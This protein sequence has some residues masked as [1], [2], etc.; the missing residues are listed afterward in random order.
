MRFLPSLLKLC[1]NRF[2]HIPRTRM[3][4][5]WLQYTAICFEAEDRRRT[6]KCGAALS[7]REQTTWKI[8]Q[9]TSSQRKRFGSTRQL[10]ANNAT[11]KMHRLVS[12]N[13]VKLCWNTLWD[14][15]LCV[16]DGWL[17]LCGAHHVWKAKGASLM[18]EGWI[19]KAV[20]QMVTKW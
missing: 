11:W 6:S 15:W 14:Q 5:M 10:A 13:I 18:I 7:N 20:C 1:R 3:A 17:R 19:D 2:L 12:K 4:W 9:E 16:F 8:L